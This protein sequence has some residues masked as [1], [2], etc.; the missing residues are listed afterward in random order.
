[1]YQVQQF[2]H[3]G[4]NLPFARPAGTRT[5][6]QPEGDIFENR[7]MLKQGVVLKHEADLTVAHGAAAGFFATEQDATVVGAFQSSDDSQQCGFAATGRAEQGDQLAGR[8]S[9]IDVVECDEATETLVQSSN[10]DAHATSP[11]VEA[12]RR[13]RV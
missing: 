8:D 1:L 10:V 9:Q 7:H 3:L 11:G 6:P 12:R 2:L 13:K 4:A 5:Y